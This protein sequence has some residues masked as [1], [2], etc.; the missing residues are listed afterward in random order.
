MLAAFLRALTKGSSPRAYGAFCP[1]ACPRGHPLNA[2]G[3]GSP[4]RWGW[5]MIPPP[6]A[7]GSCPRPQPS[8]RLAA[9]QS[10]SWKVALGT[11]VFGSHP[12]ES[13]AT[14]P[15]LIRTRPCGP[16]GVC[17]GAAPRPLGER[18]RSYGAP[19]PSWS[20][21][22]ILSTCPKALALE[23]RKPGR[24]LRGERARDVCGPCRCLGLRHS[25][26]LLRPGSESPLWSEPPRSSRWSHRRP[27]G[28][29][30][31]A[32]VRS[33]AA[34]GW[35]VGMSPA[36]CKVGLGSHRHDP[37]A[38]GEKQDTRGQGLLRGPRDGWEAGPLFPT[39]L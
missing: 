31:Q 27:V 19:P 33:Q 39:A 13:F 8:L 36:G 14:S 32:Q 24:E 4:P 21:R 17:S 35:G 20:I 16:T 3:V 2:L 38:P 22:F 25:P 15:R 29:S 23:T 11:L 37:V 26:A 30:T 9:P 18:C 7:L 34:R 10:P 12:A 28:A 5:D 1:Q 6:P